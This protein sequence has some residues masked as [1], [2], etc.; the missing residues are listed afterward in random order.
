MAYVPPNRLPVMNLGRGNEEPENDPSSKDLLK[1]PPELRN[2]VYKYSLDS[3]GPI[4]TAHF[5]PGIT[6]ASRI[7][8]QEALPLFYQRSTF[9]AR[10]NI[11]NRNINREF[12]TSLSQSTDDMLTNVPREHLS[13]ITKVKLLLVF[14][15]RPR[16]RFEVTFDLTQWHDFDRAVRIE[17]LLPGSGM[18][19]EDIFL[20]GVREAMEL[21]WIDVKPRDGGRRVSIEQVLSVTETK[22]DD[23]F[24]FQNKEAWVHMAY[25]ETLEALGIF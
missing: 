16:R 12:P 18:Q 24:F 19:Y 10:L 5:Q 4:P 17:R 7:I 2:M 21:M 15:M 6:L 1:L 11:W 8:R 14:D 23:L 9:E 25:L 20:V 13:L 22:V 3:L